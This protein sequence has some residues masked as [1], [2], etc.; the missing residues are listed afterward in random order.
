MIIAEH[1]K[2]FSMP[3][4]FGRLELFRTLKQGDAALSFY[5]QRG[6]AA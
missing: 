4:V 6:P 3:V 2:S 5:S 1:R